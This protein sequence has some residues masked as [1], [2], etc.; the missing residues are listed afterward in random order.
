MCM[1]VHPGPRLEIVGCA[2]HV[3]KHVSRNKCL[4]LDSV[5]RPYA[6]SVGGAS[7]VVRMLA[8]GTFL[9]PPRTM[10]ELANR[11]FSCF[12]RGLLPKNR[13]ASSHAEI[14]HCCCYCCPATKYAA[15]LS[16]CYREPRPCDAH[17]AEGD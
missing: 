8:C 14:G 15:C 12:G 17:T 3:A 2:G 4:I 5:C 11:C 1:K 10:S 16:R 13:Q 6:V 9:I 7:A